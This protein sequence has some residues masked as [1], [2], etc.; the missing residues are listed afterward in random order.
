MPQSGH[1]S[2][3]GSNPFATVSDAKWVPDKSH[4][5]CNITSV[6]LKIKQN[7]LVIGRLLNGSGGV[8]LQ[9]A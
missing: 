4:S 8:R 5:V 6:R 2:P 7:H 3:A 1:W 9:G